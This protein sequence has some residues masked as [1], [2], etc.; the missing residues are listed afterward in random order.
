[1]SEAKPCKGTGPCGKVEFTFPLTC[2]DMCSDLWTPEFKG[3]YETVMIPNGTMM[4]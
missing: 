3:T 1:M 2:Y 4:F